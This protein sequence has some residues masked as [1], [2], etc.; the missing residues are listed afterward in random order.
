MSESIRDSYDDA[1]YKSTYT[2]LY[3][4]YPDRGTCDLFFPLSQ[5]IRFQFDTVEFTSI[6]KFFDCATC[7]YGMVKSVNL[8]FSSS[9]L[10]HLIL[11]FGYISW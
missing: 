9:Y 7:A 3:Y 2:L 1:L 10:L 11:D 8:D 5:S 6:V 4:R